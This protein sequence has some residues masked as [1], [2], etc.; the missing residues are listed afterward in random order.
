MARRRRRKGLSYLPSKPRRTWAIIYIALAAIFWGGIF[1]TKQGMVKPLEGQ[2][3]DAYTGHFVT[4]SVKIILNNDPKLAHAAGIAVSQET[5]TDEF[6]QFEFKNV[7]DH[8]QLTAST[9]RYRP[10]DETFSGTFSPTLK[11]TPSFLQGAVRNAAGQPV[12]KANVT[13]NG[14]TIQSGPGGEFVYGDVPTSGDVVVKVLGYERTVA[15]FD[16]TV[17]LEV[18][19]NP[20]RVK[21]VYLP[22]K[23]ANDNYGLQSILNLLDTTEVNAVVLDIKDEN[24]QTAYDSQVPFATSAPI[25]KRYA[26]ITALISQLHQHHAHII[27]RLVLFQDPVLTD[28]KP[29][30]TLKSKATSHSWADAAGYNWINPYNQESWK[31]F[32]GLAQEVAGLGVDEIQFDYDRFPASGKLEEINYGQSSDENSRLAATSGIIRTAQEV[33]TPLGVFVSVTAFGSTIVEP[34]DD[35]LVGQK[36]DNYARQADFVSPAIYP[37]EWSKGAFNLDIPAQHPFEVVGTA[38]H[39]SLQYMANKPGLM[40]PWLEAYSPEN[41]TYGAAEIKGEIMA[42]GPEVAP[43]G[44]LLWNPS[45]QYEVAIFAPKPVATTNKTSVPQPTAQPSQNSFNAGGK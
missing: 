39:D 2:L 38:L 16:H 1:Y 9:A 28:K 45:G 36:L 17:K 18:T 30:W 24:G 10:D 3:L 32:I 23:T 41:L 40:R 37:A 27:G 22:A 25:A 20:L 42:A 5:S 33:L 8:Y 29:E 44:W 13:L 21:G 12:A 7:T 31:F 34:Q 15:H 43:G 35:L 6:G 4:D 14:N 11:L 19:I 26:N